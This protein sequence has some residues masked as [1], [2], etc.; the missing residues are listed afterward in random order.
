MSNVL[1]TVTQLELDQLKPFLDH[2]NDAVET[3]SYIESDPVS[4]MHAFTNRDDQL[5][6]GFFAAIMAWGRRDIVLSKVSNL[7]E[8]MDYSP[9]AFIKNY[10]DALFTNLIGFK[11]RTFT[12]EDVHWLIKILKIIYTKFGSLDMFWE[13]CYKVSIEKNVHY[14][15]LFHQTFFSQLAD[16]PKRTQKHIADKQKK[17]TCKRLFLFL[18]WAVRKNSPVDLGIMHSIPTSELRIPFD[19]H[20]A[21]QARKLGLLGRTQNDWAALDELHQRLVYLNPE[22][23]ARYDYALFGLGVLKLSIPEK[24]VINEHV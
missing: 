20:V 17:S 3:S 21:R 7:L 4:F 12:A 13:Y 9:V 1:R 18:R 6:A 10:D 22:D 15:D 23:P 8:R 19:V 2:L 24:F 14:M 5:I 11:H 16:V